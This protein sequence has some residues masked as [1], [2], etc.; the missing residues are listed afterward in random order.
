MIAAA[1]PELLHDAIQWCG[2]SFSDY[3]DADDKSGEFQ[4][5]LRVYDRHGEPCRV[6]PG[7]V[8]RVAIGNRSAFYCPTCQKYF[9]SVYG[10]AREREKSSATDAMPIRYAANTRRNQGF[11]LGAV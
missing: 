3:R 9:F 8:K 11:R 6:C 2:T 7:I 4:N 5:H 1:I 10:V